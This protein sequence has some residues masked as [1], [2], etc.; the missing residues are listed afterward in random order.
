MLILYIQHGLIQPAAVDSN[1]IHGNIQNG[2]GVCITI[3]NIAQ[4]GKNVY[5]RKI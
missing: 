1:E 2:F 4:K 3:F 5:T